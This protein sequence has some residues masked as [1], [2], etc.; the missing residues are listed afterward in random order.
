MPSESSEALLEVSG[1]LISSSMVSNASLLNTRVSS[2]L[3]YTPLLGTSVIP[4]IY[5]YLKYYICLLLG[6]YNII[7]IIVTC[8]NELIVIHYE[9]IR[10]FIAKKGI[11]SKTIEIARPL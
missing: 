2:I 3:L 10:N 11:I 9:A 1:G 4:H 7:V 6:T 5:S 8:I